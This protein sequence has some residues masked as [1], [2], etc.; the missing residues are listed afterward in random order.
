MKTKIVVK[1]SV[2]GIH[3]WPGIVEDKELTERVGFLQY[4]HR[5]QFYFRAEKV[6]S[7]DDRD[8]E[9]IDLKRAIIHY[10]VK[11][12]GVGPTPSMDS[13]SS[14]CDFGS[15]SCE[16]LGKELVQVFDLS[17]CEVLEDDEN[18]AVVEADLCNESVDAEPKLDREGK[19]NGYG[20]VF[21][22]GPIC[23][24]KTTLAS[25]MMHEMP[26]IEASQVVR[27]ILK[28]P[29]DRSALGGKPELDIHI[30][31]S[32]DESLDQD[33][34]CVISGVRQVSILSAYPKAT[35]IWIDTPE[36]ERF[37]RFSANKQSTK[38]S[39]KSLS[40]FTEAN[41]MDSKLGLD[42][43]KQY[44]LNRNQ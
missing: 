31:D 27:E 21:I 1:F 12:Y 19:P 25:M 18:G 26:H 43:V 34:P 41:E 30:I 33:G 39:D 13:Y 7:H 3:A 11:K 42:Q 4:P 32:I 9:I 20:S 40:A 8:I 6:V 38:D 28:V 10:L 36:A 29:N 35:V 24:G 16:M 15:L 14:H 17:K 5:H 2:E 37:R 23:S 22:C 44:I